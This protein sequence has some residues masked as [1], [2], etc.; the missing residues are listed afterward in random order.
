MK[1]LLA[2]ALA[3]AVGL[4]LSSSPARAQTYETHLKFGGANPGTFK[5]VFTKDGSDAAKWHVNVVSDNN[6]SY[7]DP[8]HDVN[9]IVLTFLDQ[10]KHELNTAS[11][12]GSGGTNIDWRTTAGTASFKF[13]NYIDSTTSAL[14]I[15]MNASNQFNGWVRMA[16]NAGALKYIRVTIINGVASNSQEV[17]CTSLNHDTSVVVPEPGSLVLALPAL[18]PLGWILRRRFSLNGEADEET[19]T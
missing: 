8:S 7:S 15:F 6:F 1:R 14:P 2:T 11:D 19:E 9:E 12:T 10:N 3:A 17:D 18:A 4:L 13:N 5:V 16:G